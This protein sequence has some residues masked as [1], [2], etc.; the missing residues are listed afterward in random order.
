MPEPFANGLERINWAECFAHFCGGMPLTDVATLMNCNL[1]KLEARARSERWVTMKARCEAQAQGLV[2][3]HPDEMARRANLVQANREENHRAF[4]K[5]R[6]HAMEV[7]DELRATKGK[8]M[9]KR[10][11]HNKGM[12]VEHVCDMSMSELNTLANY[13]QVIANGT[14]AALGDSR[15]QSGTKEDG[16]GA[17][18]SQVPTIQIILPNV[19]ARPRAERMAHNASD[20]TV[21]E[22]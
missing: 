9:V 6:D 20:A 4:V 2:P 1:E 21:I 14:Y 22:A 16:A 19:I 12:I 11:W 18:A 8:G 7:I 5:L 13:M 15:A 17:N 10:Y 3:V